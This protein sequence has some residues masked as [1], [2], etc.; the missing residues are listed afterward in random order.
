M[1]NKAYMLIGI[2][3]EDE[4]LVCQFDPEDDR[5][6]ISFDIREVEAL[7][8]ELQGMFTDV[9]YKIYRLEAV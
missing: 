2:V 8:K 9:N 1:K 5:S 6:V 7:R 4:P 3:G